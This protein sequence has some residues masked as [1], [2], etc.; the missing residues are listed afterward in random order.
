MHSPSACASPSQHTG[1]GQDTPDEETAQWFC[2]PFERPKA[3]H[4]HLDAGCQ[5]MQDLPFST[6]I[7][8]EC[9]M[10]WFFYYSLPGCG[11]SNTMLCHHAPSCSTS[12]PEEG[13]G[14]L[15]DLPV[16]TAPQ[17]EQLSQGSSQDQSHTQ[18]LP[19]CTFLAVCSRQRIYMEALRLIFFYLAQILLS[20]SKQRREPLEGPLTESLSPCNVLL[21]QGSFYMVC[22]GDEITARCF[23]EPG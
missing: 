10:G 19:A 1:V 15:R 21:S 8:S 11:A 5:A 3:K 13:A 23:K 20:L 17:T 12:H 6:T 18:P 2:L 14:P 4:S 16:S 9:S 7:L 22:R